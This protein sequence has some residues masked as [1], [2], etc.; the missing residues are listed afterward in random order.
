M[1]EHGFSEPGKTILGLSEKAQ[2]GFCRNFPLANNKELLS[3]LTTADNYAAVK[4]C[5]STRGWT[6]LSKYFVLNLWARKLQF[7]ENPAHLY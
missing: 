3:E 1:K 2:S 6:G 7:S 4:M 5:K